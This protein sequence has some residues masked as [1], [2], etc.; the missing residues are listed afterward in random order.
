MKLD[1]QRTDRTDANNAFNASALPHF[2]DPPLSTPPPAQSYLL[3]FEPIHQ[4]VDAIWDI[5]V[6]LKT[7]HD[8]AFELL[9]FGAVDCRLPPS[10]PLNH[11]VRFLSTWS[12]SDKRFMVRLAI[13]LHVWS[14]VCFFDFHFHCFVP[15]FTVPL[16]SGT[17]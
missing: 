7:T 17:Y 10:E 9:P 5:N 8:C 4:H 11:S 3:D 16:S 1:R 14:D 13:P 2:F 6:R 15:Q 12:G